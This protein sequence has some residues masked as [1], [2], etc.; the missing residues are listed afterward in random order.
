VRPKELS[1]L[2]VTLEEAL[3]QPFG[4]ARFS[5]TDQVQVLCNQLMII[6]RSD[7]L[8]RPILTEY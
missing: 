3:E 1:Q 2:W 4:D 5:L 8:P 7:H 6:H